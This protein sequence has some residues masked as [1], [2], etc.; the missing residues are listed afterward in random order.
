M[1]ES[2]QIFENIQVTLPDNWE[3]ALGAFKKAKEKIKEDVKGDIKGIR[4]IS[5]HHTSNTIPY[6]LDKIPSVLNV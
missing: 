1:S 6:N 2:P 4:N 3:D 5:W